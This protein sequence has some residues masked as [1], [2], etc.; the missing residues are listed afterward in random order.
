MQRESYRTG[1]QER[2]TDFQ[3]ELTGGAQTTE[4][5]V[6][7]NDWKIPDAPLDG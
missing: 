1:T 5:N 2:R 6:G 7:V 4:V 3:V